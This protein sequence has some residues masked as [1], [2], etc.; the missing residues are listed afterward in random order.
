MKGTWTF[1]TPGGAT[2]LALKQTFQKIDPALKTGGKELP[3]KDAK[4]EGDKINFAVTENGGTTREYS[5]VV[6]GNTITGT[7]KA[8][9]GP[10]AKWTAQR[11]P[12]Q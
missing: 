4:L 12:A 3:V 6:N 11:R 10:E 2:E 8:G 5:G 1:Q 7:S 9:T